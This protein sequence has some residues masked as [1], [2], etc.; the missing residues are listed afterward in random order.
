[1][2][3]RREPFRFEIG[4]YA[5]RLESNRP[6]QLVGRMASDDQKSIEYYSMN[7]LRTYPTVRNRDA[8]WKH[9]DNGQPDL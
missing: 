6:I 1:M 8:S 9:D 5:T 4:I 7:S 3:R 2:V